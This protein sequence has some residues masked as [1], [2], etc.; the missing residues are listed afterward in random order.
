MARLLVNRN[1]S[2]QA[3]FYLWVKTYLPMATCRVQ[4]GDGL[5]RCT[6]SHYEMSEQ[7]QYGDTAYTKN[8]IYT[9]ILLQN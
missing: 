9:E 3:R 6:G 5:N 7:G 4:S 1:L 8:I 2:L